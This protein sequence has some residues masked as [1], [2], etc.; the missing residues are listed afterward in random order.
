MQVKFTLS[1][2]NFPKESNSHSDSVLYITDK[3]YSNANDLCKYKVKRITYISELSMNYG[4]N[5]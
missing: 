5:I 4:K 2:T 1:N 3:N